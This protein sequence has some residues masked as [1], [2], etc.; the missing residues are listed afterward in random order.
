MPKITIIGDVH[1]KT[2][3][4]IY[5]LKHLS[6]PS[7]QVGDMGLGFKGIGLPPPGASMPAGDH[8]F[9][10]GNHDNP[11]K[12]RQHPNYLGDWGYWDKYK[13]FWV[14]G[15]WSIDRDMRIE[16][17]SWWRDEELSY[18]ELY[19]AL[20]VYVNMKPRFVLSHDC[21]ESA[22]KVLLYDLMSPYFMAKQQCATSRTCAVLESMLAAHAPEEWI[23]G[24][25]HVNKTFKVPG[26]RTIFR[27]LAELATYELDTEKTGHDK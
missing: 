21:P 20:D 25:Y 27:C 8:K 22:N 14:A 17:I 4:Y 3:E 19:R 18:L 11:E 9:F 15:A 2:G 13:L 7:I 16:G 26:Y 12:C 10:R 5:K 24:H 23:F 6:T 1:G